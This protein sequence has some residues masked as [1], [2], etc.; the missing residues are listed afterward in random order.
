MSAA[1]ISAHQQARAD[2][3]TTALKFEPFTGLVYVVRSE[4]T[5]RMTL[6]FWNGPTRLAP[7][8]SN[9]SIVLAIRAKTG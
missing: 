2:F 6:K 5:D 4:C 8:R 3:V 1:T 9:R 7:Y